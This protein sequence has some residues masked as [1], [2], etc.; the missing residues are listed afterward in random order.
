MLLSKY[1]LRTTS[2]LLILK[3]FTRN[4]LKVERATMH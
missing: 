2:Q 3:L 1:H 4:R